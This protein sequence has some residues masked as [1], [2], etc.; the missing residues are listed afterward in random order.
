MPST[1]PAFLPKVILNKEHKSIL[2]IIP[3]FSG[4][5]WLGL[6]NL[7]RL[8]SEKSYSLKV[9]MT[10]YDGARYTAV[11]DKFEVRQINPIRTGGR[12]RRD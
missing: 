12:T 9:T 8:T 2:I 1:R 3:T 11:Y 10:D 7:H 6:E 5:S 4:E